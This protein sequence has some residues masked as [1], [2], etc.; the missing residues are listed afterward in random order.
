MG[1]IATIN[2]YGQLYSHDFIY[3]ISENFVMA[4]NLAIAFFITAAGMIILVLLRRTKTALLAVTLGFRR[5]L[6][7]CM[8]SGDCL[9]QVAT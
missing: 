8:V 9:R 1:V 3:G 5:M 4:L 6:A 7:H 2:I